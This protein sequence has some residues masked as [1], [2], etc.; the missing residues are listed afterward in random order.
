MLRWFDDYLP[1][2]PRWLLA[3]AADQATGG[4][5]RTP[6]SRQWPLPNVW[7]GVSVENQVTADMRIPLLLDT[8]A[9]VRFVSAEP[10]L[11]K[12]E[13]DRYLDVDVSW[14]AAALSWV[15]VGG[16]SGPGA[17]PCCLSWVRNIV[18]DCQHAGVPLFVK[19]L[20]ARPF[21]AS[22]DAPLD[23]GT[24]PVQSWLHFDDRKGGDPSEWTEYLRVRQFPGVHRG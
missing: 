24:W 22:D 7:L 8:P 9:A 16:E 4:Q 20:G 3:G 14:R 5:V 12:V 1:M 13:L 6:L 23:D 17:R 18:H 19:Q 15:I 10:L 2:S 21:E 11:D